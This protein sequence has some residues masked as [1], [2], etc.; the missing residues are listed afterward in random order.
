MIGT[1]NIADSYSKGERYIFNDL[2][3]S[4]QLKEMLISA[5]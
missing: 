4:T 2:L 3:F 1:I 5:E